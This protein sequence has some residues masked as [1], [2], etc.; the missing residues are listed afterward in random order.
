MRSF[1]RALRRPLVAAAGV[2]AALV[3]AAPAMPATDTTTVSASVNTVLSVTAPESIDF[4]AVDPGQSYTKNAAVSVTS[5]VS[6]GYTL[7]ASR[8]A[9]TNGDIP[10]SYNSAT[11]PANATAAT[12]GAIPTTGSRTIGASAANSVTAATGD[13]WGIVL[14]LGP[15]PFTQDGAHASTLTF[16]VTATP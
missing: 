13:A 1:P 16:T 12:A 2:G 5:N 8:T 4:G 15:V 14:G 9:F 7:S 3:M 11:A 10:L 6:N